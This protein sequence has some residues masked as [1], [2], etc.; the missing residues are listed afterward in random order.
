MTTISLA[1]QR[2]VFFASLTFS[3]RKHFNDWNLVVSQYE[4]HAYSS[5]ESL[6]I[7]F[8]GGIINPRAHWSQIPTL[9][10]QL[11]FFFFNFLEFSASFPKDQKI[12]NFVWDL[13]PSNKRTT[14]LL[15][16]HTSVKTFKCS[17]KMSEC[18]DILFFLGSTLSHS[19]KIGELAICPNGNCSPLIFHASLN[20]CWKSKVLKI[21]NFVKVGKQPP[22]KMKN[23]HISINCSSIY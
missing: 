7:Y 2:S 6:H 10:I 22:F 16:F 14:P 12:T 18:S 1:G 5:F 11:L 19:T 8:Y 13:S 4:V 15:L 3:S 17:D 23:L 20:Y 21:N 9:K